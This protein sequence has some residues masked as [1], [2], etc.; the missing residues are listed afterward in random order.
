MCG[1][2]RSVKLMVI[3]GLKMAKKPD[4][5]YDIRHIVLRISRVHFL[6]I[7]AYMLSI[8]VLDSW[9]IISH[10]SVAQRW[11]AAGALMVVNTI[12]WYLCRA[13]L[14]NKMFYKVLL[15]VLLACDILFAAINVYWTRGM[16]SKSV[17][18]FVI[19]IVSAGL[20]RSRS[21]LAATATIS[22][23]AYSMAAVRYFY[24]NYGQGVR[25]ELYGEIVF[26]SMCFFVL[27]GLLMI[28]FRKAPD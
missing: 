10:E 16:A 27:T 28:G 12:V 19:P 4:L 20:S 8:I 5:M 26:Y 11:T 25:T 22:A 17:F 3:I 6:Y 2:D 7:L 15:I 9:N 21:L 23:V 13:K 24:E 1:I 14:S 18:L